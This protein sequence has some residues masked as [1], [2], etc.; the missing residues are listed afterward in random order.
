MNG[1]MIVA[2]RAPRDGATASSDFLR[3]WW[4]GVHGFQPSAA[5]PATYEAGYA[6]GVAWREFHGPDRVPHE[7]RGDTRR[8]SN[9]TSGRARVRRRDRRGRDS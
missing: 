9:S 6:A 8:S 1:G 5:M 4:C 7:G 2:A 3:A